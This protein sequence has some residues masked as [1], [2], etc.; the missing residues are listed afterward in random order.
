MDSASGIKPIR[1]S[2]CWGDRT[3]IWYEGEELAVW[4]DGTSLT[5]DEMIEHDFRAHPAVVAYVEG[6]HRLEGLWD[7]VPAGRRSMAEYGCH[8]V[9][10]PHQEYVKSGGIVRN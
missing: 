9:G 6:V 3:A 7:A 10:I 1:L 5:E 2:M 8:G 4:E